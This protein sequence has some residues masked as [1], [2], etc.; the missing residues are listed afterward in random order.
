MEEKENPQK[1]T[2]YSAVVDDG[3]P[4][5]LHISDDWCKQHCSEIAILDLHNGEELQLLA[6]YDA[7]NCEVDEFT[8]DNN[9]NFVLDFD[10]NF[11]TTTVKRSFSVV[12][13]PGCNPDPDPFV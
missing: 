6:R 10:G 8:T 7:L 4:E 2:A 1:T 9:G 5:V 12:W 11:V 13:R 3:I